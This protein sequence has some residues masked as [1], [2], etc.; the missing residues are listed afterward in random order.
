MLIMQVKTIRAGQAI[1][2]ERKESGTTMRATD[3]ETWGAL[4]PSDEV[5]HEDKK[6]TE[7]HWRESPSETPH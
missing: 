3:S 6:Q 7:S 5:I 1:T 2:K 4:K